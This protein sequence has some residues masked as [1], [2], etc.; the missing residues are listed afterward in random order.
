MWFAALLL[1]ALSFTTGAVRAAGPAP[2][3]LGTSG[4]Y[5]ILSKS[6]ITDV[7]ASAVTGDVGTSP[8]TGAA[9]TGLTCTEVTGT[10]YTVDAAG[11]APCSVMHPT[12]LTKA[13]S[14]MEAAYTDAA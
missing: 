1:T 10:I 9:I 3:N 5:V 7:P 6:G 14:D 8:I 4:N 2:V 11:P 12:R 13:V